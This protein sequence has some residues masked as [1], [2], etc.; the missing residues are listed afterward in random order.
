MLN[1]Q[2]FLS[3]LPS[4]QDNLWTGGGGGGGARQPPRSIKAVPK[5]KT[6]IKDV[7][8]T[9]NNPLAHNSILYEVTQQLQYCSI[10]IE[11][12]SLF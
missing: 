3:A 7:A 1:A 4:E 12:Y 9:C 8:I 5:V 10:Y 11:V 2:L 6:K